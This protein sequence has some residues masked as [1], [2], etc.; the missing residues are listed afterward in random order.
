M[1]HPL[2]NQ[3]E[4][5]SREPEHRGPFWTHPYFVYVVLSMVMFALLLVAGALAWK[6]GIIPKR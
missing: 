2:Q 6:A 3:P 5:R 4:A 1:S